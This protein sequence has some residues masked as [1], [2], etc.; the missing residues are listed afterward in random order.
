MT[1]INTENQKLATDSLIE[2]YQIDA[3][4]LG[5]PVYYFTNAPDN[6]NEDLVLFNGQQYTAIQIE[7]EGFEWNGKGQFPRPKMRLSN[8]TKVALAAIIEFKGLVGAKLVRM[9]TYRKYL[10]NGS[11]P[12]TNQVLPLDIYYV[13][14]ILSMTKIKIE[15]ELSAITDQQGVKLPKT[16]V[17]RDY[18]DRIYRYYDINS[19]SFNYENATCPFTEDLY[20]KATGD[21]TDNPTLDSCGKRLI[22]CRQRFGV[23]AELPYSGF[24]GVAR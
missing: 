20:F 3:S 8:V 21:P 9:R 18:C 6:E 13:D 4:V 1:N 7:S 17:L 12:G 14:R 19:G 24:P 10:D 15:W 11:E 2:L 16:Q 22:N 5:G 23:N